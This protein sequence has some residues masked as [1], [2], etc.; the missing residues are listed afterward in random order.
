MP[1]HPQHP[2]HRRGTASNLATSRRQRGRPYSPSTI[3]AKTHIHTGP[4]RQRPFLELEPTDHPLLVEQR[5]GIA[6]ERLRAT[7][8]AVPHPTD[9]ESE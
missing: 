8:E 5:P 3:S 6:S 2:Q 7:A 1:Q 9:S 4:I